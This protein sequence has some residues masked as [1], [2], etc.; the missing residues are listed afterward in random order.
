[1]IELME[2][3]DEQ[4]TPQIFD[5][6]R[7]RVSE[8]AGRLPPGAGVPLVEDDYGDI[9]GFMYAVYAP[10]Y[11]ASDIHDISRQLSTAL[12]AVPGGGQG[13]DCRR[14]ARSAVR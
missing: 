1:M 11:A 3:Y 6:L 13:A 2:Q 7:R 8:A 10:G 4:E 12:K 14:T 5:E 9:Y